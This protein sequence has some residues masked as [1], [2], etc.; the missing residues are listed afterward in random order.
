MVDQK[1]DRTTNMTNSNAS[2]SYNLPWA[3]YLP[4]GQCPRGSRVR[5]RVGLITLLAGQGGENFTGVGKQ[6]GL[7]QPGTKYKYK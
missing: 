5:S 3:Q 1:L 7:D 6:C 4:R 2:L